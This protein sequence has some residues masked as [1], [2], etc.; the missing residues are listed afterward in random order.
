[1][2]SKTVAVGSSD[3]LCRIVSDEVFAH[4]S[5]H[6]RVRKQSLKTARVDTYHSSLW[7][8][9]FGLGV[10]LFQLCLRIPLGQLG[11]P[12]T[13]GGATLVTPLHARLVT[14]IFNIPLLLHAAPRGAA[15]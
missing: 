3:T 10:A 13:E 7:C 14:L 5:S 15:E 2:T 1:V 4:G 11:Y 9:V 8:V 12:D 6:N